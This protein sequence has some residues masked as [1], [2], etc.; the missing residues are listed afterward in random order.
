MAQLQRIYNYM[1]TFV[2]NRRAELETIEEYRNTICTPTQ[3]RWSSLDY[4]R[5]AA[6]SALPAEG[7]TV[8]IPGGDIVLLDVSPPRLDRLVIQG[9]LIFDPAAGNL[10]L[11][12]GYIMVVEGGVLQVGTELTPFVHS[13]TITLHGE[14]S[15]A[16][17]PRWGNKV[18]AVSGVIELHGQPKTPSWTRLTADAA[19]NSRDLS[20]S[21]GS[22]WKAYERVVIGSSSHDSAETETGVID[23]DGTS[24][25]GAHLGIPLA[26]QHIGSLYTFA[27][28]G[29]TTTYDGRSVVA[30][31]SR[32]IIIR[33]A[34]ATHTG[35]GCRVILQGT[36]R[37]NNVVVQVTECPTAPVEYLR[38]MAHNCMVCCRRT[39]GSGASTCRP[40]CSTAGA[41]RT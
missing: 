31:L 8:F 7:E 36:T 24:S 37:I 32:N 21:G 3:H 30:S 41:R 2:N 6:F 5:G 9:Q 26:Q 18:L 1:R 4:W 29:A 23:T 25:G 11:E 20:F 39:A 10:E 14:S 22:D 27:A 19:A 15:S 33:G 12:A 17:I 34:D 16:A 35:W 38:S 13:A 28:T 40:C